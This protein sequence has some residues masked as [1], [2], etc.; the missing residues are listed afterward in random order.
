MRPGD[1]SGPTPFG[2]VWSHTQAVTLFQFAAGENN[3]SAFVT[4]YA[5]K[6]AFGSLIFDDKVAY[7]IARMVV[8]RNAQ[9]WWTTEVGETTFF[10]EI[11]GDSTDAEEDSYYLRVELTNGEFAWARPIG[12]GV[13][14]LSLSLSLLLPAI[15]AAFL[16]R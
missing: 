16:D 14:V 10:A 5:H 1:G 7:Y 9:D 2:R 13:V 3:P 6:T 12:A 15:A 8:V 11:E 4:V